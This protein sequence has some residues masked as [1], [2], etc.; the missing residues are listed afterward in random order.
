MQFNSTW[1]LCIALLLANLQS[2]CYRSSSGE[3]GRDDTTRLDTTAAT[4][5]AT[6]NTLTDVE[7]TLVELNGAPAE[8][9]AG[10][11]PATLTLATQERRAS[12]F[13]GCNRMGGTYTLNGNELRFSPMAMTRMACDQGMELEA[14]FAAA[15]EATRSYRLSDK[16]LELMSGDTVLARLSRQ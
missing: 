6:S 7:W 15:I 2:A 14:K 4:T 10:G 9:G 8:T 5:T 16:Q 11:R 1:T 13:A 3:Y 12:G